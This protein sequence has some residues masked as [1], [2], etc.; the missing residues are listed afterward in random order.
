MNGDLFGEPLWRTAQLDPPWLEAGG[1]GRGAQNHYP[2]MPVRDIARAVLGSGLWRP[3]ADAHL[4]TWFTDN[5]LEDAL[6]LVARLGFRYVRTFVWV[7][8]KGD[9]APDADAP[10]V[11]LSLGQYARGAH[12]S[13]LFAVRGEG[14]APEVMTERRDLASVFYAPVPAVDGARVHSRKPDRAYELIE[15]R[16]RGPYLECFARRGRAGWMTWG[17]EPIEAAS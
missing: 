13:M 2:L 7:K 12:E 9:V 8:T 16:S 5:F 3:H 1:G 4:W 17:N 11:R 6:W 10:P 15:A 14:M